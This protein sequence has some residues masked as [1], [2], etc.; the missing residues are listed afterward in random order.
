MALWGTG[1]EVVDIRTVPALDREFF[2]QPLHKIYGSFRIH[3]DSWKALSAVQRKKIMVKA[4]GMQVEIAIIV[5]RAAGELWGLWVLGTD[6][7]VELCYPG[8]RKAPPKRQWQPGVRYRRMHVPREDWM[9][10]KGIRL[11][12]MTRT[13]IDICRFEDFAQGLAAIES[14][15]RKGKSKS[16]LMEHFRCIGNLSGKKKFLKALKWANTR[17][18]SASESWAKAQMIEAGIDMAKVQQNP[19]VTLAGARYFPDFLYEGWLAIEINGEEK[20]TGKHGDPVKLMRYERKREQDFLNAGFSRLSV[21]WAELA[22]GEFIR[23]LKRRIEMK[24]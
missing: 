2:K 12:S 23:M 19:E 14:Y 3:E 4:V 11:T 21:G 24:M 16:K 5:G 15:L 8:N 6:Y 9:E 13:V 17:S 18:E 1:I 10:H 20:Y 22:S 7:P